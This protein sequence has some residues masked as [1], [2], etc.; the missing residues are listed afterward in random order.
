MN[1]YVPQHLRRRP[2]RHRA[3]AGAASLF[4]GLAVSLTGT[5]GFA[6]SLAAEPVNPFVAE[7]EAAAGQT[8]KTIATAIA[9]TAVASSSSGADVANTATPGASSTLPVSS[10]GAVPAI[11]P[12]TARIPQFIDIPAIGTTSSLVQLGLNLDGSLE[13]PTDFGQA[14]WFSG[15][16][17]PGENGPAV[18]AGHLD[19]YKG[20][21]IFAKL[22]LLK[23]GDRVRIARADGV[24]VEFEVRR[25]DQYPKDYFPTDQ[26]YGPTT[27]PELRLITCGGVFDPQAHSYKANTVV[28]ATLVPPG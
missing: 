17:A 7:R 3:F 27:G 21:A 22:E 20:P 5:A 8:P 25:I 1:R 9:V 13:V 16:V 6:P 14:G 18:I 28:Y 23:P 10:A 19:S 12:R 2:R 26:V 15:G 11:D 24:K 4:A